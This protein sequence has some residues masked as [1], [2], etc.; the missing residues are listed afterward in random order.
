VKGMFDCKLIIT[1]E[2]MFGFDSYF[3]ILHPKDK[4]VDFYPPDLILSSL[5][6]CIAALVESR[7]VGRNQFPWRPRRILISCGG[8]KSLRTVVRLPAGAA[9]WWAVHYPRPSGLLV[10]RVLGTLRYQ[11]SLHVEASPGSI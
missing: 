11:V 4:N 5:L 1:M 2:A 3:I 8:R 9:V 10:P 6:A 7:P